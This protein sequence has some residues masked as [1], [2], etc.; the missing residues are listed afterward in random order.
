MTDHQNYVSDA[1]KSRQSERKSERQ[2][3]FLPP[4]HA[5]RRDSLGRRLKPREGDDGGV[6]YRPTHQLAGYQLKSILVERALESEAIN[7]PLV[8]ALNIG[9][10]PDRLTAPLADIYETVLDY[11]QATNITLSEL[12]DTN[13]RTGIISYVRGILFEIA[14]RHTNHSTHSL[15]K[16]FGCDH[17]SVSYVRGRIRNILSYNDIESRALRADLNA[18]TAS[19]AN[20]FNWKNGGRSLDEQRIALAQRLGDHI[21]T[22]H[23]VW[24]SGVHPRFSQDH[25]KI[26]DDIADACRLLLQE[27]G[28]S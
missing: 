22:L 7:A 17:S 8:A 5:E 3:A 28:A 26:S 11:F 27:D 18:I 19:L 25:A 21:K 15:A 16:R 10:R 14:V 12:R 13:H 24:L 1:P 23:L 9:S 6:K 2:S 20:K 4:D